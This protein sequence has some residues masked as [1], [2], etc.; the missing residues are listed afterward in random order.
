MAKQLF[1]IQ[2]V[3]TDSGTVV[4]LPGGGQL[5]QDL[6]QSVTDAVVAKGVGFLKTEAQVR[7]A[8]QAG[9]TE[10]I[11]KMKMLTKTVV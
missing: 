7:V 11:R 8:I 2:I 4:Q 10:T 1:L 9:F 5:E 3:D 6:I